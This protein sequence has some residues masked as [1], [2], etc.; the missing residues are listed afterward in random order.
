MQ[1]LS[2]LKIDSISASSQIRTTSGKNLYDFGKYVI[3]EKG[4]FI[5]NPTFAGVWIQHPKFHGVAIFL[6]KVKFF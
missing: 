6:E 5:E 2:P 3:Q 4:S 1:I